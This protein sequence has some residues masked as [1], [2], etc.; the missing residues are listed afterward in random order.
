MLS[1][2]VRK[3]KKCHLESAE[4]QRKQCVEDCWRQ[5]IEGRSH[6][7]PQSIT[8]T[9]HCQAFLQVFNADLAINWGEER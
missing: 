1:E 3:T 4:D 8:Q 6:Y 2:K 5:K 9:T 7:L